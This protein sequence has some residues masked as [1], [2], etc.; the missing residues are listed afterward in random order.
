MQ[1]RRRANEYSMKDKTL[2]FLKAIG[3]NIIF[4]LLLSS[5]VLSQDKL[6]QADKLATSLGIVYVGMPKEDLYKT[7]FTEL[8]Q[9]DYHK[10]GNEEWITFSNWTTEER[11]DLITFHLVDGKV[12]DWEKPE[13][14]KTEPNYNPPEL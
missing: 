13:K 11:G 9:K 10:E 5:A 4:I 14:P 2:R 3:Y 6:E 12:V 8:L 1:K 7:G